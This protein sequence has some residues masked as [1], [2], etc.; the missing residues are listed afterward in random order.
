MNKW[1]F[2]VFQSRKQV[3]YVGGGEKEIDVQVKNK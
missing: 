1:V 2:F 3:Q